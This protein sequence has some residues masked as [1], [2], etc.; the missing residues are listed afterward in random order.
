MDIPNLIAR[1]CP[2]YNDPMA[3]KGKIVPINA[4]EH[5]L[6]FDSTSDQLEPIYFW[7]LDFIQDNLGFKDV[8]KIEDNFAA[9]PGGGYFSELG[10]KATKMQ[11]EGMKIMATVNTLIRT[12]INL[13]YDLKDFEIRLAQYDQANSKNKGLAQAGALA[14]KNIWLDKVDMPQ[15][16]RGSIHQ[17][18]YELGFTTLR[19]AFFAVET[20]SDV[21]RMDINDRVKRVLKPRLAEFLEWKSRSEIELK[22]RFGIE[23]AYL[24]S[25]VSAL[26]LYTRWAKPYLKIAE[27]LGMRAGKFSEEGK[28]TDPRIINAFN[29][30]IM[31]FTIF[32]KSPAKVKGAANSKEIPEAFKHVKFKR[33]Y[34]QCILANF[35]FRGI[36]FR[37]PQGHYVFGGRSEYHL[38]AYS[39]NEDEINL[40]ESELKK[41]DLGTALSL[42]EDV[43]EKSL[44]ELQEDLDHFLEDKP[45]K[46]KKPEESKKPKYEIGKVPPDSFQEAILR[47][48]LEMKA[49]N[50]VFNAYDI[51]KKSHGMCSFVGPDFETPGFQTAIHNPAFK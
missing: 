27:E 18:T 47:K 14:L 34:Y 51:Y 45:T 7:I 1:I 22:K 49:A 29:T 31:E 20:L 23:K 4:W 17:M 12:I 8:T 41:D 5:S 13:I 28:I 39:L 10:A 50:G 43:T 3:E 2:H 15:K 24:K 19:D 16:G 38:E 33:K 42:V 48:F 37:T 40:L 26:K 9:S 25:E 46:D 35:K 30:M 11:E 6:V 32:A 21:D 36:P 44:K